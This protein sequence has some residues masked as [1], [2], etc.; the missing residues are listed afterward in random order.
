MSTSLVTLPTFRV[1]ELV[2]SVSPRT[3]LSNSSNG[4]AAASARII[5]DRMTEFTG[6]K[7]GSRVVH[8][9]HGYFG[10]HAPYSTL[11]HY[12]NLNSN[13]LGLYSVSRTSIETTGWLYSVSRTSIETTGFLA[14]PGV[15]IL[16]PHNSFIAECLQNTERTN[17][18]DKTT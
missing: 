15:I 3:Y 13:G 6:S 7:S 2:I 12:V 8:F 11:C 17:S 10:A 18:N 16:K 4:H 1:T 9:G 14:H 5:G